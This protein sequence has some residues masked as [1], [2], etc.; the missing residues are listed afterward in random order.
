MKFNDSKFEQRSHG[1][2][3]VLM[4]E[5]YTIPG[6]SEIEI[7]ETVKDLG[8]IVSSNIMLSERI[9]K[10][11]TSAKVKTSILMRRFSTRQEKSIMIM[12]NI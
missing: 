7:G 11:V 9:D 1:E 2:T 3:R 5:A 4:P 12:F 10:V 6:D 8:V